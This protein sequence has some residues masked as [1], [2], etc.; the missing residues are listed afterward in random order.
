MAL[1]DQSNHDYLSPMICDIWMIF[2]RFLSGYLYEFVYL[3][4]LMN[5]IDLQLQQLKSE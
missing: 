3:S 5:R 4:N 2:N 1:S